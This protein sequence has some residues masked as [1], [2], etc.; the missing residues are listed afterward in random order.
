MAILFRISKMT[1]PSR[2]GFPDAFVP[3]PRSVYVH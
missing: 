1:M 3:Q 2:Y